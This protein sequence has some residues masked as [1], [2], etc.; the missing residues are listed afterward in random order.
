MKKDGSTGQWYELS[1]QQTKE[2]IAHAVRDAVNSS[3]ARR[4]AKKTSSSSISDP[5]LKSSPSPNP[6]SGGALSDS[7]SM[8]YPSSSLGAAHD[9]SAM[10]QP[11][12]NQH[13][14]AVDGSS[15]SQFYN[16]FDQATRDIRQQMMNR[17]PINQANVS[18]GTMQHPFGGPANPMMQL[19]MI[20]NN[21]SG[22]IPE[23]S[24]LDLSGFVQNNSATS[25]SGSILLGHESE[26][27]MSIASSSQRSNNQNN[28]ASMY[29]QPRRSSYTHGQPTTSL[30]TALYGAQRRRSDGQSMLMNRLQQQ[31]QSQN[32]ELDSAAEDA[33]LDQINEVLGPLEAQ[34]DPTSQEESNMDTSGN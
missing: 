22:M 16:N 21:A 12:N 3:E 8:P 10:G 28:L 15:S 9:E 18:F 1:E 20:R 32:Q 24:G 2:K 7:A 27:H 31:L 25:S 33:F 6:A 26:G 17:I 34:N 11:T 23:S 13:R 14:V 29:G 5:R 19:G 4:S 30:T